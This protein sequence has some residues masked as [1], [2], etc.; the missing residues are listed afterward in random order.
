MLRLGLDGQ[1][2]ELCGRF[3]ACAVHAPSHC[4]TR[5]SVLLSHRL[6]L[7]DEICLVQCFETTHRDASIAIGR[8]PSLLQICPCG[9]P[10]QTC[11]QAIYCVDALS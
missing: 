2:P 1:A 11:A 4:D 7:N 3:I 10:T 5:E 6:T 8:C 9:L